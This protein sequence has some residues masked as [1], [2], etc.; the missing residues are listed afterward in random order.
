MYKQSRHSVKSLY[1]V[2]GGLL[3]RFSGS[4]HGACFGEISVLIFVLK[5]FTDVASNSWHQS[6]RQPTRFRKRVRGYSFHCTKPGP[7][8]PC[9]N[10]VFCHCERSEAISLYET[11][12]SSLPICSDSS[13]W[14]LFSQIDTLQRLGW[15]RRSLAAGGFIVLNIRASVSYTKLHPNGYYL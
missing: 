12:T 1:I 5:D 6:S 2:W 4:E 10:W 11:A 3:H 8:R 15:A 14:H 7:L 13:Q 9:R